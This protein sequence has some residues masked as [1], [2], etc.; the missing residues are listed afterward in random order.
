[1]DLKEELLRGIYAYGYEKPTLIQQKAIVPLARKHDIIV[2]SQPGT[3][4]TATFTIGVLQQIDVNLLKCQA[5]IICPTRE[6]AMA[7]YKVVENIGEHL[8]IIGHACVGGLRVRD[9]HRIRERDVHVVVG[10]PGRVYD[11]LVRKHFCPDHIK[12]FILDE[13]DEVF[14]RGYKDLIHDI[15]T[16]IPSQ[17]QVGMLSATMPPDALEFVEKFMNYPVQIIVKKNELTLDGIKQFYINVDRKEY[18]FETLCDLYEMF[19][20]T[21]SV[22][23]CNTRRMVKELT[24]KLRQKEFAVTFMQG[25]MDQQE[26]DTILNEFRSGSSR[27]LITT[28]LLARGIDVFQVS[29]VINYDLPRDYANYVHRIAKS[30]CYGRKGVAIN[31]V[32]KDDQRVIRELEQL[33]NT[34]IE[35]APENIAQLV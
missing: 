20:V 8:K 30:G 32:T 33:Y 18:K 5:L 19:N 3:G 13:A 23:F 4:K 28:D 21:H 15:L 31:F 1:M 16:L 7:T 34:Q 11:M 27:I 22:I 9:H 24:D 6:L 35:E 10:T 14:S 17:I 26:R 2:E 12:V 29:L 25:D